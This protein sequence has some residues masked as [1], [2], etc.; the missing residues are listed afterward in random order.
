MDELG[1]ASRLR[2]VLA[3]DGMDGGGWLRWALLAHT[4]L[5]AGVLGAATSSTLVDVL[6]LSGLAVVG[7]AGSVAF[8][9]VLRRAWRKART[10]PG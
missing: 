8:W 2:R 10:P 9:L 3:A 5:V 4:L 6:A 1:N 7:L